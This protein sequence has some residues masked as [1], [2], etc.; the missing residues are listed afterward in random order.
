[1]RIEVNEEPITLLSEYARIPNAFEVNRVLD[2]A[3]QGSGRASFVL[4]ERRI[5]TEPYIKNY[6]AIKGEGPVRWARRFDVSNWGLFAARG[7]GRLM[8]G[9]AVAFDTR[10]LN[11]L[12]GRTD[13]AVLWDIRVA[14]AVRGQGVGSALFRAAEAWATVRGCLQLKVETQN[15]NV[16][17]CRFYAR[18]GCV[19]EAIHHDAYPECPGE[20]QLLWYKDLDHGA[21]AG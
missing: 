11:M 6:D 21:I 14:P 17:A 1:V 9:A 5:D 12:E 19:L 15:I 3:V 8:G 4:S 2:V 7:E 13:L 10:G 18:H 16:P 20:I